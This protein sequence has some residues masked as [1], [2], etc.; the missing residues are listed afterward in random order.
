M[1]KYIIKVPPNCDPLT[2]D[3]WRAVS[4]ALQEGSTTTAKVN[5]TTTGLSANAGKAKVNSYDTTAEYLED[6]IVAS[7]STTF[8]QSNDGLGAKEIKIHSKVIEA[9][10]VPS[11]IITGELFFDTD[12]RFGTPFTIGDGEADI[13][14][15]LKFDGETNDGSIYWMEDEDQFKFADRIQTDGGIIGKITTAID[16][17]IILVSDETVVCNKATNFTVTLPA[18]TVGQK[19]SIKN[20]GLGMV[21]LDANGTDKI[22]GNLTQSIYQYEC[23]QVQ[24]YVAN[25]WS[26]L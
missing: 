16:T 13:D 12:A 20:V 1:A 19:F 15:E 11:D 24:C 23:I 14:Y 2:A 10:T 17:Y 7:N 25:N 18:A 6:K 5:N 26:I 21:T 3:N 8:V 9:T 22:D 4:A